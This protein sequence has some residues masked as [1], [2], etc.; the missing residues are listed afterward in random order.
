[1]VGVLSVDGRTV[2]EDGNLD[3]PGD[4]ALMTSLFIRNT[5]KISLSEIIACK[6]F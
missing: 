5:Y 6:Y 4:F 2:G 3:A 1:M